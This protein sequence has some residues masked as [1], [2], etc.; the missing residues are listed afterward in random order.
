M[1]SYKPYFYC[2][3]FLALAALRRVFPQQA[4]QAFAW[5]HSMLDPGGGWSEFAVAVGKALNGDDLREGLIAAAKLFG[6][7]LA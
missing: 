2:V 3:F 5:L 4:E 7:V 6:E 1:R